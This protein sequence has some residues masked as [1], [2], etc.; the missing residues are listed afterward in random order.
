MCG[1]EGG[2][3]SLYKNIKSKGS[4]FQSGVYHQLKLGKV[5]KSCLGSGSCL[6]R[7][8]YILK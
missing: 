8:W 2:G 1:G 7:G 6:E 5:S 4:Y 3:H